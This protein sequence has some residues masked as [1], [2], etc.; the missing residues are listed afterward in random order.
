MRTGLLIV[1]V[2]PAPADVGYPANLRMGLEQ[3]GFRVASCRSASDIAGRL[4]QSGDQAE[5]DEAMIV[6]DGRQRG[7]MEAAAYA[8]AMFPDAGVMALLDAGDETGMIPF[9]RN[10]IDAWVPYGA[11]AEVLASAVLGHLRGRH[12]LR[13]DD[14]MAV[15]APFI[16]VKGAWTLSEQ[17]WKLRGPGGR[18]LALT[19]IERALLQCLHDAPNHRAS[20]LSLVRALRPYAGTGNAQALQPADHSRLGVAISRL[21]R[22]ASVQ[23]LE[24]PLKSV[25]NWGYMF[26]GFP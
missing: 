12:R 2:S 4:A 19:T 9:F 22:K 7:G 1:I 26:T 23:G 14:G 20:H 21:R 8:Q 6:I 13:T 24:L 18:V 15:A 11:S 3:R 17:G 5:S 25:H 10:G 16:P